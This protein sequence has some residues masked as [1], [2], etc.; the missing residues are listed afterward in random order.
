MRNLTDLRN[1]L[2]TEIS[3]LS[4]MSNRDLGMFM[5]VVERAYIHGLIEVEMRQNDS[6]VSPV[7]RPLRSV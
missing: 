2:A 7:T 5:D 1:A 4:A 6:G 3:A